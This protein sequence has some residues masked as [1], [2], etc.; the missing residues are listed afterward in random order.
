MAAYHIIA[1][2]LGH[3]DLDQIFAIQASAIA[4]NTFDTPEELM[5]IMDSLARPDNATEAER[6]RRR[7]T[8]PTVEFACYKLDQCAMWK[9][10]VAV[11]GIRLKGLRNLES[12]LARF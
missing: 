8:S 7:R 1:L 4:R 3:E 2:G 6:K 11:L 10:W 5:D 9:E 12:S